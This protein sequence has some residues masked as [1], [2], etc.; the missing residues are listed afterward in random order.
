MSVGRRRSGGPTEMG[1]EQQP[2]AQMWTSARMWDWWRRVD[3][4]RLCLRTRCLPTRHSP[5][6]GFHDPCGRGQVSGLEPRGGGGYVLRG[7]MGHE[8]G[9]EEVS[10]QG[11]VGKE[12]GS[13]ILVA[14]QTQELRVRVFGYWGSQ[15]E[16]PT[17][18]SGFTI[19]NPN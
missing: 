19:C 7:E 17:R 11:P 9:V 5:F 13:A 8:R 3:R 14:K 12:W 2:A 1:S 15:P 4:R 10:I 6:R 16:L 18:N